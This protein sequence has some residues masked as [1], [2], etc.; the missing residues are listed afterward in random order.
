[1]ETTSIE[2]LLDEFKQAVNK[3]KYSSRHQRQIDD[4][5]ESIRTFALQNS[6][7]E[8]SEEF[9][10]AFLKAYCGCESFFADKTT[11]LDQNSYFAI[12]TVKKINAFRF[13]KILV[14]TNQPKVQDDDFKW[15]SSDRGFISCYMTSL[16]HRGNSVR[17]RREIRDILRRF[18]QYLLCTSIK[19]IKRLSREDLNNYWKSLMLYSPKYN[20]TI[21][22][23]LKSLLK[24]AQTQK[25]IK[26]D[27]YFFYPKVPRYEKSVLP[28][29]WTTDDVKKIIDTQDLESPVGKR[30]KAI[31]ILVAELGMRASD[32]DFLKLADI[33][34][35]K[36]QITFSQH[37]TGGPHACPLSKDAGWALI[38][39]IKNGRPQSDLPYVFLSCKPPYGQLGEK[40]ATSALASA[41]RKAGIHVEIGNRTAGLHS[42]R[43][44]LATRLLER[45]YK[46]EDISSVM[47]HAS[48]CSTPTYL[49][50]DIEGLR[51]CSIPLKEIEEY[52][53]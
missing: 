1:M 27:I 11:L 6:V 2:C 18:Y 33:D 4:V 39:Y 5:C 28:V 3:L 48:I 8:F 34:W 53:S 25:Y 22:S 36:N 29:I 47:G 30:N 50:L 14:R 42:L 9:G 16:L 37:K 31:F 20:Y 19:G 44:A 7:H 15:A 10:R 45:N 40:T 35:M 24:Y 21:I 23:V 26:S 41:R 51:N 43:H 52:A 32:I 17:R 49:H 38:D 12:S 46:L 13:T